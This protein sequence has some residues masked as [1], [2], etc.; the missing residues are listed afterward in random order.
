MKEL[1]RE[2]ERVFYW[3]VEEGSKLKMS[4]I[5]FQCYGQAEAGGGLC[6]TVD[7][8]GKINRAGDPIFSYPI[9]SHPHLVLFFILRTMFLIERSLHCI[10]IHS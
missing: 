1:G 7:G 4:L 9:S 10:P 3:G 6:W 2:L 8:L 5:S